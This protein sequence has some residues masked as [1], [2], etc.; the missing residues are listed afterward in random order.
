MWLLHSPAP[1]AAGPRW[2]GRAGI[3]AAGLLCEGERHS[4]VAPGPRSMNRAG[5][6]PA[7]RGHGWG[8]G[9]ATPLIFGAKAP[10]RCRLFFGAACRRAAGARAW[11]AS[12]RTGPQPATD[13]TTRCPTGG[14]RGEQTAGEDSQ[15]SAASHSISSQ[16]KPG[17]SLRSSLRAKQALKHLP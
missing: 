13:F 12:E 5:E 3:G 14:R 1:L 6:R 4:G 9:A 15:P 8:L 17:L 7:A 2:D 16:G 10:H 11:D